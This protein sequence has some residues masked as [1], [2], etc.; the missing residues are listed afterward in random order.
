MEY[1]TTGPTILQTLVY[2]LDAAWRAPTPRA[3]PRLRD[4]QET[5]APF[6]PYAIDAISTRE[7]VL[8]ATPRQE[9]FNTIEFPKRDEEEPTTYKG[10][11]GQEMI[12]S[13]D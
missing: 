11:Y 10:T 5:V 13:F 1:D 3:S 4:N 2:W 6:H 9:N 7:P 8:S 12:E